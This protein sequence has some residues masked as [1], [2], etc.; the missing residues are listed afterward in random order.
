MS[1]RAAESEPGSID[2]YIQNGGYAVKTLQGNIEGINADSPFIP[3][4]TIKLVTCLASLH[5][6]GADYQFATR[7]SMDEADNLY[8][9]GGGD[10]TLTSEDAASLVGELFEHGVRRV[11]ALILD[12][13]AFALEGMVDGSENSARPYDAEITPLAINYN[14]LPLLVRADHSI[15]SGEPQTPVLPIMREIGR[16]MDPGQY[17]LNVRAFPAAGGLTNEERYAGEL[18]R[19][20]LRQR[21]IQTGDRI[22]RG[23][24]PDNAALLLT[25]RSDSVRN[26]IRICLEYSNNFIANELFIACGRVRYGGAGTWKKGRMALAEFTS[27]TLRLDPEAITMVEGSGLSRKNQISPRTMI[28][29]LEAFAPHIDLIPTKHDFLMKSGTLKGVYCYGGYFEDHDGLVPF[30]IMLNQEVNSR[31]KILRLLAARFEPLPA[32]S[33]VDQTENR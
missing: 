26:I 33:A 21:G 4:S 22:L 14:A 32:S 31:D 11:N 24:V 9:Q 2:L 17:R 28:R 6:L 13:S 19:A 7:F 23:T 1:A 29:V 30:S 20:L 8:I 16:S 3:A 27:R 18:F 10:P 25:H 5:I 12:G 15:A